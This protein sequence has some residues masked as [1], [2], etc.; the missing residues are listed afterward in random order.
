MATAGIVSAN[1]IKVAGALW[2]PY[3]CAVEKDPERKGFMIDMVEAIVSRQ[4]YQFNYT[5]YP[6]R[7]ALIATR[8]L[9]QDLL[10]GTLKTDAPDFVFGKQAFGLSRSC[11]VTRADSN[12]QYTRVGDLKNQRI[13]VNKDQTFGDPVDS[14]LR[15]P[16]RRSY[17]FLGSGSDYLNAQMQAVGRAQVDVTLEDEYVVRDWFKRNGKESEYRFAG[18]INSGLVFVSASPRHP[19]AKAMVEMLDRGVVELRQ[20]GELAK[21]LAKYGIAD[22]H[23]P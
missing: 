3:N 2:C 17:V 19:K 8:A 20:S 14:Y 23:Q 4:G 13:A 1:E 16:R 21:I 6:W 15:D 7:R 10:A 11:F 18:C 12:W 9:D 5:E 22:W